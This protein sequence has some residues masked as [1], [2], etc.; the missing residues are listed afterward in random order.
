MRHQYELLSVHELKSIRVLKSLSSGVRRGDG[1]IPEVRIDGRG[2]RSA[3]AEGSED[4]DEEGGDCEGE[5]EEGDED[6]Q[7]RSLVRRSHGDGEG[8]QR[9][10][11]SES[12]RV[13]EA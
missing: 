8:S 1:V 2:M 5:E 7:G 9:K 6:F 13:L 12:A 10:T 3:E 4:T 11:Q